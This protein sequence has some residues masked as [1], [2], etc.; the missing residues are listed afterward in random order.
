MLKFVVVLLI[1]IASLLGHIET[2]VASD[3]FLPYT[4]IVFANQHWATL[5]DLGVSWW[6]Y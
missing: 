4:P 2:S 3:Y 5:S 1:I 6:P